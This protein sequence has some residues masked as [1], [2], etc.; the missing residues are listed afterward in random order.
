MSTR[1][2]DKAKRNKADEFYTQMPDIE[3]ELRHYKEH[4]RGKVVLCNCDDPYESNF[5]K[6]FAMNFNYLGLKKL[7]ATSYSDSP[8]AYG[9]LPLFEIQTLKTRP[10]AE[11][12]AC[13]IEITEVPDENADGAVDLSDVENLLKSRGNVFSFLEGDG[14]FRSQECVE[15]LKEADIVVTNPPFSLFREYVAQLV[16]YDKKFIIIGNKNSITYKEIFQLIKNGKLWLGYRNI[17]QDM[18]FVV[19]EHYSYEKIVDGLRVKHIMGCW[20][21]NLDTT[22]RHESLTLYKRYTP[23]E[24]PHY[25]NYDAINVDKVAEIPCDYDGAMGVPITFLDKYNPDQFVIIGITKTWFGGATKIYPNQTQ[26]NAD[27]KKS[28]VSKL[29]DGATLKLNKPPLMQT[30]Y[31]V[32]NEVFIQLYA[33]I[34]IKLKDGKA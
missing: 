22:K 31:I 21:T 12:P 2:L 29:N 8:V 10:S 18:W 5:F 32:D 3:A 6:Y 33:R 7:I 1:D 11:K 13:R 19:P 28:V 4:F 27:G 14:D 30:Y 17:N 25:D 26:V 20:F 9:Q 24:Y 23:E 15:L 16:E 34:V